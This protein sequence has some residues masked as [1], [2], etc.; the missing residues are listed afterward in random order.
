MMVHTYYISRNQK[1]SED[2][3]QK[4][5]YYCV[6]AVE[7]TR[8]CPVARITSKNSACE[9]RLNAKNN[10]ED[11]PKRYRKTIFLQVKDTTKPCQFEMRHLII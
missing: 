1:E 2:D 5:H 7:R 10:W 6:T 4:F 8:L 3:N 9:E 11:I